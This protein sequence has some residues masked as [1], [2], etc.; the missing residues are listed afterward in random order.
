[1]YI[2]M[3]ICICPSMMFKRYAKVSESEKT[4]SFNGTHLSRMY[5]F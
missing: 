2:C 5:R 4:I 1:M 3:Y